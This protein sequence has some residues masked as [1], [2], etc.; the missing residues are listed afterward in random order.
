MKH[1]IILFLLFPLISSAQGLNNKA[2]YDQEDLANLF[3]QNKMEVYKFPVSS[4]TTIKGY[5]YSFIYWNDTENELDT[6]D[7]FSSIKSQLPES[8]DFSM[9]LAPINRDTQNLFRVYLTRLDTMIEVSFKMN[10]WSTSQKLPFSQG[11]Y[12]S[13]AMVDHQKPIQEKTRILTVYGND[14][15]E[16]HCAMEDSN[17]ELMKR[18]K[19]LIVIYLEPI[20]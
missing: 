18:M 9:F 6:I 4:D 17:E 13:R 19:E 1:L 2:E 3:K 16:L 8:T 7:M 14:Q 12:G 10:G 11:N 20:K 5:N 15:Q